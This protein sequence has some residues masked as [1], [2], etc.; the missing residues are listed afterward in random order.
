M[1]DITVRDRLISI[2]E[3]EARVGLKQ[4]AIYSRMAQGSFP[5]CRSLGPR[6]VRWVESEI[7]AWASGRIA[8]VVMPQ[9]T[10]GYS[11]APDPT[12]LPA[13]QIAA[14]VVPIAPVM[15]GVYFLLRGGKV[16]YV[17]RSIRIWHRLAHHSVT[18]EFDAWHWIK[19]SPDEAPGLERKY[20]D[21]LDPPANADGDTMRARLANADTSGIKDKRAVYRALFDKSHAA[22]R[23]AGALPQ[24][25]QNG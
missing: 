19:C 4:S 3:V 16:I 9:A 18:I 21:A 25:G 8:T 14:L 13:D 23:S 12:L 20:I 11:V 17:G 5:R 15:C 7:E 22:K 2:R 1:K 24:G 6:T 10:A